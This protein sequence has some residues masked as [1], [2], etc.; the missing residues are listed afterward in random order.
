[1]GVE[2]DWRDFKKI[3]LAS[4]TLATLIGCECHFVEQ[5]GI[6]HAAKLV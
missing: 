3:C 4:S 1:M 5:L 6:E 2:V